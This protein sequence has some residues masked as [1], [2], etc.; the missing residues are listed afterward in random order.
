M[1]IAKWCRSL[2]QFD[3]FNL[4]FSI[5]NI[6]NHLF[7][8]C[9]SAAPSEDGHSH[10]LLRNQPREMLKRP[11]VG[12][13]RSIGEA[14]TGNLSAA[15]VIA[16]TLA[17]NPLTRARLVTT[18]ARLPILLLPAFHESLLR[19]L[20]E[21]RAQRT[22]S[23]DP[24]R[25]DSIPILTRCAPAVNYRRVG[26][27]GRGA[28]RFTRRSGRQPGLPL[29]PASPAVSP[30]CGKFFWRMRGW[31]AVGRRPPPAGSSGGSL[32]STPGTRGTKLP[33]KLAAH[34]RRQRYPIAAQPGI[35]RRNF[36]PVSELKG[37]LR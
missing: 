20:R 27:S 36:V 15:Q 33:E 8:G 13:L 37:G 11:V 4:Q 17:A 28:A 10:P 32:R 2:R 18:V 9:G 25:P 24:A 7:S 23:R 29:G 12:P 22:K 6:P 1:Q 35:L 14:T 30:V 21:K 26:G 16:D 31:L 5:G 19:P 34:R 3:I